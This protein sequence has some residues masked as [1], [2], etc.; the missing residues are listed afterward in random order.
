LHNQNN[1]PFPLGP[2]PGGAG[3]D[4]NISWDQGGDPAAQRQAART[5]MAL[6]LVSAGV[7]PI[8]AGDE[9]YRTEFGNNN[10]F[11]L[12]YGLRTLF[13]HHFNYAKAM[14]A[15]RTTHPALRRSDFFDGNDHNGNGLKDVTWVRDNGQE[16]DAGYLADNQN[17]FIAFR[18]DGTEVGDSSASIFVAYNGFSADIPATL[19]ANLSGSRWYL[20]ADTASALEGQDNVAS[21]PRPLGTA[22]Y[23]TASR[24]VSIFVEQP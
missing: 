16:A 10:P 9:M 7:P 17:H 12:D 11:N 13:P 1:Q 15:F 2:S 24:S 5:G 22:T 8:V 4:G 19:P 20:V 3:D 14:I 21:P 23:T 18:L 6:L